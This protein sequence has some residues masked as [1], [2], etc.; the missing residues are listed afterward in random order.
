MYFLAIALQPGDRMPPAAF[1]LDVAGPIM[2]HIDF[3][4]HF[5]RG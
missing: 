2:G 1:V 3:R 4:Y 5:L